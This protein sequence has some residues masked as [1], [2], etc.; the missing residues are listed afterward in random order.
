R[1]EEEDGD[2]GV[3]RRPAGTEREEED[4]ADEADEEGERA[5]GRAK[6]RRGLCSQF[7]AITGSEEALARRYL[8]RHGWELQ[9]RAGPGRAA[10]RGGPGPSPWRSRVDLTTDGTSSTDVN[11]T[12]PR[13]PED[14]SSFSLLT[15]NIDGLDLGN[16]QDRARG[17][18]SYLA[19]YS[20][21]VVFLQEV[22]PQ[23]LCYLQK[24]AGN[25]TFIPGNIDGYFTAVM[26]KNSR[27]K[28]VKQEIVP[29]PTTSMMRNLLVVHV[30]VAGNELCLMTSH[31]ESTKDHSKERMKQLQI[32]F[33]EMQK[34]SESATVIFGGDTNLR[35]SEVN[36][37]GGLPNGTVDVW[38]FLGKPKHCRYTWDTSCN[39]NLAAT[40]T[41]KLRFDRV[42][43]RTASHGGQHIIPRGMDLIGLEKLD[44]G[45]FPSD[46]WGV[47]CR[48]DVIL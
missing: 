27:V 3:R 40:Y 15:W 6:R 21:D 30:N 42:Y 39:S 24:R 10:R 19:L 7:A 23:Y 18:C 32:V 9:V 20:P 22:I 17:V 37:L 8:A 34:E 31:L 25:Y 14:D 33:K 1:R 45:R 12:D 48:F 46:H 36:K 28:L 5:A 43:F 47:L 13:Q 26:L 41:C 11:G 2:V 4:E 16:Q 29:F 44:C 35:D 38:E